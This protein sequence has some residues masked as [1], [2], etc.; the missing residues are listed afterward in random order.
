MPGFEVKEKY[1][2]Y[3]IRDPNRY[4]TCRWEPLS[5]AQGIAMIYCKLKGEEKWEK[6]SLRFDR[7]KWTLPQARK[8]V[9]EH[10]GSF[11]EAAVVDENDDI[12]T[13]YEMRMLAENPTI[14][15]LSDDYFAVALRS[16]SAF[17][18]GTSKV[19]NLR[20]L[21]GIKARIGQ[22]AENGD[23][24]LIE[25]VLFDAHRHDEASAEA[26]MA[27]NRDREIVDIIYRDFAAD[28]KKAPLIKWPDVVVC[29]IGNWTVSDGSELKITKKMLGEMARNYD[30]GYDEAPV[31][32]N[33]EDEGEAKGWVERLRVLGD[34]LV[35]R[36]KDVNESFREKIKAGAWKKRS[37]R[38][39]FGGEEQTDASLKHVAFLGA[40]QPAVKGMP[41]I[42]FAAQL[43]EGADPDSDADLYF[44]I[45]NLNNI[46][47]I[48]LKAEPEKDKTTSQD[49][50][51]DGTMADMSEAL[52]K[53]EQEKADL[54]AKLKALD[55]EKSAETQRAE[56][57]EKSVQEIERKRKRAELE[58]Y[59]EEQI[60]EG[61]LTPAVKDDGKIVSMME[62]LSETEGDHLEAFKGFISTCIPKGTVQ[63]GELAGGDE[64]GK[65]PTTPLTRQVKESVDAAAD[66]ESCPVKDF[67]K[68]GTAEAKAKTLRDEDP[69]LS[70]AE[71]FRRAVVEMNQ[72]G[73]VTV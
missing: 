10:K 49:Q 9:N 41:D 39:H 44:E 68:V 45:D 48:T 67:D 66:K 29:K 24:T 35:A 2:F 47:P 6:Q 46:T 63:F 56:A 43:S 20:Q 36:L 3:R 61:R 30:P 52:K 37:I 15:G 4:D 18:P 58:S 34:Y 22:S 32:A 40:V 19:I 57:A 55:A 12:L 69:S 71:S 25:Y 64:K 27:D 31:V 7:E 17:V 65:L 38:I 42:E 1:I 21:Q 14:A 5:E 59:L 8:W 72:A 50:T 11:S 54:E 62:V 73:E 60:R 16:Q 51:G 28:P 70:K 33:H 53:A 23:Q 26:W 13:D